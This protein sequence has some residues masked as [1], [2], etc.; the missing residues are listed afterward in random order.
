MARRRE[1][2]VNVRLSAVE[3]GRL[4]EEA[5]RRGFRGV[6]QYLRAIGLSAA[7][8]QAFTAHI[9]PAEEGGFVVSF[10]ALPGCVTQG[11][12]YAEALAM[13]EECLRGFLVALAKVGEPIPKERGPKRP[14]N[15]A[16][17]VKT[18]EAA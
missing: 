17:I 16:L 11:E 14:R 8:P 6:G 9:E 12:T 5:R 18:T 15:V 2:Q 3:K 1:R 7:R 10:P 4:E 13:A